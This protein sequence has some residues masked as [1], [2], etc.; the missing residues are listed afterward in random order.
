MGHF[1][2]I[3]FNRPTRAPLYSSL[4]LKDHV[5]LMMGMM[6]SPE[7]QQRHS[8]ANHYVWLRPAVTPDRIDDELLLSFYTGLRCTNSDCLPSTGTAIWCS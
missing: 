1:C 3:K 8:L 7:Q 4:A 6:I 5:H 2:K